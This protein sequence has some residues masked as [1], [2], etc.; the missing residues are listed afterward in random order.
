MEILQPKFL[1]GS[2]AQDQ[3]KISLSQNQRS[4]TSK[5]VKLKNSRGIEYQYFPKKS[6]CG[7]LTTC[8]TRTRQ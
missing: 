5:K 8:L 3:E 4:K 1:E 6:R 2:K 7:K